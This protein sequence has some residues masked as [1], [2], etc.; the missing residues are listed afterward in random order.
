M[1]GGVGPGAFVCMHVHLMEPSGV[2]LGD[3]AVVNAHCILDGRGAPLVIGADTDI[4]THS[5]HLD[6]RAR[7][8]FPD[9]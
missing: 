2:T 6:T 7:S 3:R 1:L 5:H 8:E 4:G 9:T